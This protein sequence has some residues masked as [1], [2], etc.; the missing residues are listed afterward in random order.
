MPAAA[1]RHKGTGSDLGCAAGSALL[2]CGEAVHGR[3]WAACPAPQ[4]AGDVRRYGR[5]MPHGCTQSKWYNGPEGSFYMQIY[6]RISHMLMRF[7]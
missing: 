6:L 7:A 1:G 4:H 2:G 5:H 3:V